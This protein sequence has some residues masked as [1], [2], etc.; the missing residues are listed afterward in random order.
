MAFLEITLQIDPKDRATTSPVTCS[1]ATWSA[2]SDPSCGPTLTS[3]SSTSPNS[4]DAHLIRRPARF[5]PTFVA[6][7]D[8]VRACGAC[9]GGITPDALVDGAAIM[10][11][12]HLAEVLAAGTA[13][14]AF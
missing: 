12:A 13:T 4:G 10:T 9:T 1:P 8:R 6:N 5:S 11:A 2:S 3:A 7:G 14:V